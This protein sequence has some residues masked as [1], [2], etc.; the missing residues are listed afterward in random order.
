MFHRS[1]LVLIVASS[2]SG[3]PAGANAVFVNISSTDNHTQ[4]WPT[5]ISTSGAVVMQ[6]LQKPRGGYCDVDYYPGGHREHDEGRF[7]VC[8]NSSGTYASDMN[9][10]GQATV[11]G[12]PR[13]A[14]WMARFGWDN[15]T[16]FSVLYN[17]VNRFVHL[18]PGDQQQWRHRGQ[19]LGEHGRERS[20]PL[21]TPAGHRYTWLEFAGQRRSA[22]ASPP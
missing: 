6:G 14:L 11:R 5:G 13:A 8:N 16:H 17:G 2:P 20:R 18:L 4:A 15:V 3:S 19:L 10:N 1:L 9:N 22:R 21:F 7:A 12:R